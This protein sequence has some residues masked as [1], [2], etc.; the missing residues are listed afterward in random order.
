[1]ASDQRPEREDATVQAVGTL[2]GAGTLAV[3]G[4]VVVGTI[5]ALAAGRRPLV[6]HGPALDPAALIGDIVALRPEGFLW[7][8]LL[9]TVTLPAARVTVALLGF[10]RARDIRAAGVAFAV[11][12]VLALSVAIALFSRSTL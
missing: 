11:L 3:V 9:L 8:G 12:S 6:D 7:L 4:L 10:A 2:L 1:V 5:L